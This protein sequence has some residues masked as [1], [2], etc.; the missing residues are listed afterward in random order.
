[1]SKSTHTSIKIEPIVKYPR[2]A[3]PGKNYLMSIDLRPVITTDDE[4]L[5]EKEEYVIYFKINTQLF[6]IKPVGEPAVVIHRFGGTYGPARFLLTAK[7]QDLSGNINI[8]LVN[9]WGVPI[10]YFELSGIQIASREVDELSRKKDTP[11]VNLY[12]KKSD[13]RKHLTIL[14]L[15]DIQYGRHHVDKDGYRLPLY[16]DANY[17]SQLE[18][19]K[20]DLD[21]LEKE[22][23]KPNFIAVTGDI[24]EWSLR[25]EYA[26]AGK[27]IG[28]IA[29]YLGMDRRFAV[30]VPG[31]HD[32][33]RKMCQ[34]ARLAAEAEDEPF[35]PPY[36]PKFKFYAE[37][38]HRFYENVIFPA[39]IEPYKFTKG[40]LFVNFCFSDQG[41]VFAGLNSCIDES[42]EEP[43]YGNITVGQLKKAANTVDRYDPDKKML[44]I[45]LMHH[46]FVRSSENDEEN[47]KDAD[48]LKPIFLENGFHLIL[49]GHQHISR[50]EITGKGNAVVNVLATGSAGLDSKTIPDNSRRYQVI[51]I[52]ENRVRVFRRRFD[53]TQMHITG[54]GCWVPDLTPDQETLYE[55]FTLPYSVSDPSEMIHDVSEHI[56]DTY[57]RWLTDHCRYMDT[58]KLR[59]QADVIQIRLPE[60]FISLYANPPAEKSGKEHDSDGMFSQM[61]RV[62]DIED[63]VAENDCLL[64]IGDPG[65]GKTTLVKHFSYSMVQNENW[66]GLDNWLPV[67]VF[68]KDLK[69]FQHDRSEIAANAT[70]AENL[71]SY[72]F[73]LT[74]SGLDIDIVKRFCNAGNVIFLFDGLDEISNSL[75]N[76]VV[77]SFAELRRRYPDC[78]MVFSGRPFG[79]DSAVLERFGEKHVK[80]L[81]LNMKQVEEFVTKWFRFVYDESKIGRKTA[82]DM[83]A[84]IKDHPGTERFI[85]NPLMLTAICILYHDGREL[86]GQRV[87][88]YKKFVDNLLFRRFS[89]E[90]EKVHSFLMALGA[91]LQEMGIRGI[92]RT[93]AVEILGT[94]YAKEENE[95]DQA[96]KLRL[97]REFDRIEPNCGLLKFKDGQYSFRHVIFQEFLAATNL[98]IKTTDYAKAIEKY[99]NDD[100]YEEVIEL[101]IGYLSIENK[102]WANKIVEEALEKNDR[103]PFK[104]WR[105]AAK[106]VLDIHKDRRELHVTD[107]AE[108]RLRFIMLDSDAG[109]KE[110]AEAGDTLGWLGDRRDMKEFVLVKG[111]TYNL[112]RGEAEIREFKIGKYPVTNIWFAEFVEDGGYTNISYWTEQ[113]RIW[114]NYTGAKN[115]RFWHNRQWICP[116]APVVGVCWYEAYAFTTWLTTVRND[117]YE[118]RLPSQN[119]WEA[120]AAGFEKNKY[121]WSNK[122]SDDYCNTMECGINRTS[123][124]GAFKKGDTPEGI[125]DLAGN[126]WEWMCTGYHPDEI[127]DDFRFD[128]DLQNLYDKEDR[129]Q[130]RSELNGKHRDIFVVLCG[131]SWRD[132]RIN[133]CCEFRVRNI[134]N[135]QLNNVGFR[136]IRVQK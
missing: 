55:E 48:E 42:E 94:V 90:H 29:D 53:N 26:L 52:M 70:T 105:L 67:L 124:V 111:G 11:E 81:S 6:S 118:Y 136:C 74:E 59:E 110:R 101:F 56:P 134:P 30:M 76:L 132:D 3:E 82:V 104:R 57:K 24:A 37:F 20:A 31:N 33:S 75:R 130:L 66:K 9:G 103:N 91:E 40:K 128:Q 44:R 108:E 10:D 87:E 5:Y 79:I 89:Y 78:K 80:I 12:V 88:L 47:L 62:V 116:N 43:H 98:I 32:I 14:H 28:G 38:F 107:L 69:G 13:K 96:K 129:D 131:G 126:A 16:P 109:A 1:M 65:S 41:V 83:I 92:D 106:S 49:H 85:D 86:P 71:L 100:R 35:L 54:K 133:A 68:L 27:F 114:L 93:H 58:D 18:K 63:L 72:Y 97:E 73:T 112:S 34:S 15:S 46:N 61:E 120:S 51:D 84:E 125:S 64:I 119:E 7:K 122:W 113:G 60:I 45:A 21:I 4:W 17:T 25:N 95:S 77:N 102:R 115:P 127:V 19:M 99:W 22:G 23:I 123:S 121:P 36:F 2:K 135:V 117:G 39:N 8:T 50:H